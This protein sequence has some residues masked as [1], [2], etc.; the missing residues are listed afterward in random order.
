MRRI[1]FRRSGAPPRRRAAVFGSL[2]GRGVPEAGVRR[3]AWAAC[4]LLVIT[5]TGIVGYRLISGFSA[6]DA[7]YQTILT[8]TT[9]GF[10]EVHP[11]D[12][13]GRAFTIVL[14]VVGVTTGLYLMAAVAASLLEGQLY[15]DLQGWRMTRELETIE[16]HVIVAGAGRVGRGVITELA[17][18]GRA[19]VVVDHNP[20]RIDEH[21]QAGRLAVLG[22]ASQRSTLL[23]ARLAQ[24]RSLVI[25]TGNDAQNTFITLTA[26]GIDPSCYVVARCSEPESQPPMR[27]AGAAR[28]FTPTEIVGRQ[29]AAASL[30]PGVTEAAENIL[31]L[32]GALE[33]LL[34]LD[35]GEGSAQA[36]R[37]LSRSLSA[38]DVQILG[39]RSAD[40]RF[41]PGDPGARPLQQ[42][43]SVLVLTTQQ[44]IDTI[45]ERWS[46]PA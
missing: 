16:G 10:Q 13:A 36:G 14:A 17:R 29:L 42:G 12:R 9:V 5:I 30:H 28:I 41:H 37:P 6:F 22:D 39:L 1:R 15:R 3:L 23:Q 38:A 46:H 19:F 21:Q 2:F 40:G 32:P 44:S 34:W 11:L 35:V 33:L 4:G 31:E 7:L 45:E 18:R 8:L 26:L 24:A 27:Q 25:A 20:S 43:D